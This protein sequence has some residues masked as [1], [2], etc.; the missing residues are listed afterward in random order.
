MKFILVFRVDKN[1]G[2]GTYENIGIK[3]DGQYYENK[4]KSINGP[5]IRKNTV[6]KRNIGR[7]LKFI[8]N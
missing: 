8:N 3:P 5:F 7:N 4:Y 1:P 6:E 2:P